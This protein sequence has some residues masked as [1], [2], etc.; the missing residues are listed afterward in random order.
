MQSRRL[1]LMATLQLDFE[2]GIA[3]Q[4]GVFVEQARG[5]LLAVGGVEFHVQAVAAVLERGDHGGAGVRQE[6]N[7]FTLALTPASA[8]FILRRDFV[9]SPWERNL[10][11]SSAKV[12]RKILV[13]QNSSNSQYAAPLEYPLRGVRAG[14]SLP[15]RS[16]MK[17]SISATGW[18]GFASRVYLGSWA[19]CGDPG[20]TGEGVKTGGVVSGRAGG[21]RVTVGESP[22]MT[23]TLGINVL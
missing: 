20:M 17:P 15:L 7:R 9:R 12:A 18:S 10:V 13:H 8:R 21:A 5:G 6:L 3:E 16:P 1:R 2:L 4:V 19:R 14:Q 23:G 11:R 22:A